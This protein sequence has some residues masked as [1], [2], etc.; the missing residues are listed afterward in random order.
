VSEFAILGSRGYPSYYGGFETLVRHLAPYLAEHGHNV[1]VYSRETNSEQSNLQLAS[2]DLSDETVEGGSK[3]H[4]R[5]RVTRGW[6]RKSISTL[7]FG[8][9]A[10]R[11]LAKRD[12]DAVLVLNVAHGY[13][14]PRLQRAGIAT[15]INVDG[16]EWKRG[17][18]GKLGKRVFHRGASLTSRYA[19]SVVIDSEALRW[20]WRTEFNRDGVYI[21][22]GAPVLND[23]G[24]E[25]L[26]AAGLPTGGYVLL[27]TRI[28]PENNVDLL[29]DAIEL[30]K[31]RPEIIVVGEGN[32]EH[33][34]VSRLQSL[35]SEGRL[36]WLGLI[37]NQRLLDQLW[38]HAGVYWHGHSVGGTNPAL[39]QALG[40]GAPTLCLHTPFNSEVIRSDSQL[41]DPDPQLLANSIGD[42]LSSPTLS[43][44]L[45]AHGKE[46]VR[47]HYRW[48]DVCAQY[49]S[50]L[51]ELAGTRHRQLRRR[52]VSAPGKPSA[53]GATP[54]ATVPTFQ[55]SSTPPPTLGA[56]ANPVRTRQ[57]AE[58]E[59]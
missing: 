42:I 52:R 56:E 33:P 53:T 49:E 9:S 34:T 20:V 12:F 24:T 26:E 36:R 57:V 43:A 58:P 37:S 46:V 55:P 14:L 19:D 28:V 8:E 4:I 31:D 30:M 51:L 3:G 5:V 21:P 38:A 25:E 29:L 6:D 15:C 10:S 54:A 17:K 13:F 2:R 7:T 48:P 35:H 32:Y 39:L 40:A 47:T 44:E 50:V 23:V 18:W 11:D 59:A 45:G 41:V 1:T 22:Y 16:M 27:V